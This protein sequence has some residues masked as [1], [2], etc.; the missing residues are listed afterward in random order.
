MAVVNCTSVESKLMMHA[1]C[2]LQPAAVVQNN[3]ETAIG[4]H[5][6][7]LQRQSQ[8]N[9]QFTVRVSFPGF[10]SVSKNSVSISVCDS[11]VGLHNQL[12][13]GLVL[14]PSDKA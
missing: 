1:P 8:E 10:V 14:D 12:C 11:A 3:S 5:C 2:Q 13:F 6:Q 7:I 9:L 4:E